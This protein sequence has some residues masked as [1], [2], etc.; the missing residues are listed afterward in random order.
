M[1]MVRNPISGRA[2]GRIMQAA[3]T[4]GE[5]LPQSRSR[6]GPFHRAAL[7][8]IVIGILSPIIVSNTIAAFSSTSGA[9]ADAF[10]AGTVYL[11]SRPGSDPTL[12]I[13]NGGPGSSAVSFTTVEYG[14][15]LPANVRLYGSVTGTGLDRYL[16]IVVTRGIGEGTAFVPDP[17][18]YSGDG[19]GVV[20][21]G[22]L[23]DF[24]TTWEAGIADP[25]TWTVSEAHSF[26]FRAVI[27]GDSNAMG[28]TA[29][30]DFHWESRNA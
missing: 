28:L 5:F 19:P 20:F 21:R 26:R 8:A 17:V 22:T 30:A 9:D 2:E 29:S 1:Y 13:P 12:S 27:G 24:P 4:R 6:T 3:I 15:T 23:A 18:D 16:Q 14:G 11:W 25:G 7:T 10:A